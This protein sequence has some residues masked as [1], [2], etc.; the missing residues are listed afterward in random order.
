MRTFSEIKQMKLKIWKDVELEVA[1]VIESSEQE[2][3][4]AE[5]DDEDQ[6]VDRFEREMANLETNPNGV[7][8]ARAA[9][10]FATDGVIVEI[11]GIMEF[12]QNIAGNEEAAIRYLTE[13]CIFYG[14][15][16]LSCPGGS[17]LRWR[18]NGN[19][20]YAWRCN[21]VITNYETG[22]RCCYGTTR[23]SKLASFFYRKKIPCAQVLL[24]LYFWLHH[25]RRMDIADM[26]KVHPS[27]VARVLY[28][29]YQIMQ[30]E[31]S[32]G[33]MQIGGLSA[34]GTPIVVEIDESKFGK[35][36]YNRGNS[37]EG[38]WAVG[39]VEKTPERKCFFVTVN[40][41]SKETLNR[42]ITTYVKPNSIVRTD[43]WA[44][45][46]D[47]PLLHDGTLTH[48]VVNHSV[49]FVTTAGVHTNTIEG[50]WYGI[51]QNVIHCHRNKKMTP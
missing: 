37:V 20:G 14:A 18:S 32:K 49:E 15:G 22:E 38:V 25:S 17:A 29:W 51:K 41:R 1:V 26:V 23:P 30:E 43:G 35:R 45:Y 9:E 2:E 6:N 13:K 8:E 10:V 11:P 34:D 50:T 48:E 46:C 39:G 24:I 7:H 33:D 40:D 3:E 21:G 42:I 16:E 4:N 12:M 27:T 19:R 36:K 47:I 44:G 28:G 31:L 5:S